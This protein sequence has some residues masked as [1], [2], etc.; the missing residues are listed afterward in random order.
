MNKEKSN[1]CDA[2]GSFQTVSGK[3]LSESVW[4]ARGKVFCSQM[5]VDR[6][7]GKKK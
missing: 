3:P 6:F 4:T 7:L 5:C 2:C 1:Y